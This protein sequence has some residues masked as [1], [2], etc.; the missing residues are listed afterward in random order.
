MTLCSFVR[1]IAAGYVMSLGVNFYVAAYNYFV[2]KLQSVFLKLY[3]LKS[4]VQ[5]FVFSEYTIIHK[6]YEYD[7]RFSHVT[8]WKRISVRANQWRGR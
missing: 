5:R 2:L 6:N 1:Y 7:P 8:R 4:P 3:V